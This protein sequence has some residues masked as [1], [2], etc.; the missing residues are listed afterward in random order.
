MIIFGWGRQ[1]IKNY[2]FVFKNRCSNCNNEDYWH[3]LRIRT[4]FTLFFI[5]VIPYEE[6]YFLRCPVCE[7][8]IYIENNKEQDLINLAEANMNLINKKIT[9]EEYNKK[10]GY[11]SEKTE[12]RDE[13]IESKTDNSEIVIV[14][15]IVFCEYCGQKNNKNYSFCQNCGKKIS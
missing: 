5:P 10:L 15:D 1:T 4:W 12:E 11:Q 14:N 9:I 3:L 8:G 13:Y 2:G 7:K 6:K